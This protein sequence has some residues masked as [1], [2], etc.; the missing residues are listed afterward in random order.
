[1]ASVEQTVRNDL[2]LWPSI[3]VNRFSVLH[4]LF[5]VIGNGFEW[6]NGELV[7]TGLKES[8]DVSIEEAIKRIIDDELSI[9][10]ILSYMF[11]GMLSN[12]K[13]KGL[14]FIKDELVNIVDVERKRIIS[15]IN[16]LV[17]MS[18]RIDERQADMSYPS[19]KKYPYHTVELYKKDEV[20][21]YPICEY[22]RICNLPDDIKPDWLIAARDMYNFIV[23][24]PQYIDENYKEDFDEYLPKIKARLEELENKL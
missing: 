14:P 9:K 4:H 1:M 8:R 21:Y 11:L 7:E 24:N 22:S 16:D 6:K 3:H 17:S 5:C 13:E 18:F 2:L 19:W 12:V 20:K 10:D 23:H 15:D